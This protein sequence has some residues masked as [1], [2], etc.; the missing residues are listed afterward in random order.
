MSDARPRRQLVDVHGCAAAIGSTVPHVRR[1]VATRAIPFIR[2]GRKV[3]FDV[4]PGGAV[5][6]WLDAG[7]HEIQPPPPKRMTL[8]DRVAMLEELV[9]E[10]AAVH[11]CS[12]CGCR[13]ARPCVILRQARDL[14]LLD[15]LTIER[16]DEVL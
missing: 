15:T 4:A 3:R 14:G 10:L 6:R 1:L 11:D 12:A 9:G 2:V 7:S 16:F 5:D 13:A 8:K